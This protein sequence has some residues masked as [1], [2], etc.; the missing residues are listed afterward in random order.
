M[1][2]DDL[3]N[4]FC[5]SSLPFFNFL[6][7]YQDGVNEVLRLNGM[8]HLKKMLRKTEDINVKCQVFWAFAN[9]TC[10]NARCRDLVVAKGILNELIDFVEVAK[11]SQD[12]LILKTS[13]WALG[14]FFLSRFPELP[15]NVRHTGLEVFLKFFRHPND[16]VYQEAIYGINNI[17]ETGETKFID[18][19]AKLRILKHIKV[20]IENLN[21]NQKI[22]TALIHTVGF[23]TQGNDQQTQK[24]IDCGFIPLFFNFLS[25]KDTCLVKT[26]LW[27][28]ANIAFGPISHIRTLMSAGIY[29]KVLDA[30]T[31]ENTKIRREAIWTIYHSTKGYEKKDAVSL[32]FIYVQPTIYNLNLELNVSLRH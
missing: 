3:L 11:K 32:K 15:E 9:I 10:E 18:K 1:Q 28:L 23:V 19:I 17:I 4:F 12:E 26:V 8:D 7:G 22:F 31:H 25:S 24:V 20:E 14:N 16:L 6:L 30:L 29:V 13:I 27:I 21:C 5:I 2:T